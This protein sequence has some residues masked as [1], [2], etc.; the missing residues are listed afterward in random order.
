MVLDDENSEDYS[1]DSQEDFD[2][3]KRLQD[4]HERSAQEEES[5]A[6]FVVQDIQREKQGQTRKMHTAADAE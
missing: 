2:R 5:Q 3:Q 6:S 4:I 1:G